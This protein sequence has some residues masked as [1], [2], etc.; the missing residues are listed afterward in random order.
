MTRRT[1]NRIRKMK[2]TYSPS[3]D[4]NNSLNIPSTS[5]K[6]REPCSISLDNSKSL[7]NL[8]SKRVVN[9]EEHGSITL[10]HD[11]FWNFATTLS[12]P[13]LRDKVA[14][15]KVITLLLKEVSKAIRQLI[16]GAKLVMQK[17]GRQKLLFD[18]LNTFIEMKGGKLLFGFTEDNKWKKIGDVF[19]PD[20]EVIDLRFCSPS[21]KLETLSGK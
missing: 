21:V 8:S 9:D 12:Y 3:A 1:S 16:L 10:N 4:D 2:R 11:S 20:D 17:A 7:S 18:D 15:D 19:V 5:R 13:I 6:I 14:N